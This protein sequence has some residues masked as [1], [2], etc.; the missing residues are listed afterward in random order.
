[1]VHHGYRHV[2][3]AAPQIF[4]RYVLYVGER[5]GYKNFYPWLSAIRSLFNLDP[6]LKLV[7]TGT[8]VSHSE[9]KF[10]SK[11]NNADSHVHISAND[12]QMASLYKHALCFVFP[13]HYEG[14]GIPILEAFANGCPVC[15]SNASCFPE[16]AG[17]AALFFNPNDAQSMYDSLKEV[18]VSETLRGE[19]RSKGFE[20]SRDFSL[21][22]M[23]ENTCEVY[24]K[25]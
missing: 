8:P 10:F 6:N 14:F 5:K 1:M 22:S 3:E 20:R 19:L 4:D 25:L 16:V 12:A 23:V 13:S 15:L 21:E 2:V 11:W 17:D 7:C 9:I 18:L 24:R